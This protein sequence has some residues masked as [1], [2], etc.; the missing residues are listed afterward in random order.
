MDAGPAG[1]ARVWVSDHGFVGCLCSRRCGSRTR[2]NQG[3]VPIDR[4]GVNSRRLRHLLAPIALAVLALGA[5][6]CGDED[7][8]GSG[9]DS[10]GGV[11]VTEVWAREPAAGADRTAAY[12]EITNGSDD[13]V[14][15]IEVRSPVGSSV[16]L[17]ETLVDD[18]GTMSMQEREDGFLLEPGDTLVLEPGGAHIMIFEVTAE[19]LADPFDL[20]FV[21]DGANEVTASVEVV[22]LGTDEM[23]MD[24]AADE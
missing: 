2:G 19:D 13:D 4:E 18:A 23:E 5:A 6:G 1:A 21:F 9:S 3:V 16:E 17:H 10:G 8:A 14:T 15:L 7:N 22:A 20:T 12:G 11:T 24:D